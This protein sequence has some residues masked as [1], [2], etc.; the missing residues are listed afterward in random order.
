MG[1]KVRDSGTSAGDL[2]LKIAVTGASGFIGRHVVAELA[3]RS[4]SPILLLR[5]ASEVP[6]GLLPPQIVRIDLTAPPPDAFD[7]MGRPDALIHL[8][9][10]GLPN[11]RSLHHFEV[12]L[13]AQYRFLKGL[14]E[15]GLE[16]LLV[17][18]TCFEY[19]MQSGSLSEDLDAKPA[20][21]YGFAKDALRRQLEFLRESK[22]F[23]LTWARLF[24]VY[25]EGQ[26]TNSIY[27]QLK[28]AV[29]RHESMFNMSEGEQLRDYLPA[30][31]VAK[32]LVSLALAGSNAG[33]VN[34][35]SGQPVS[36]RKLVERWIADNG[37]SIGMNLGYYP[38]S[39]IEP[40]AFWGDRRKLDH[41][42]ERQ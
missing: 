29:E 9:W 1:W 38:Y 5:P 22:P 13:P 20:S 12:E 11:Y 18:G 35:C 27:S 2:R 7:V 41:C 36:I 4:I 26:A 37:W 14:L 8:A 17:T 3:R 16:S 39:D 31:D 42:Q 19:G 10:S 34:V 25:G 32:H 28:C 6:E 21:P 23:K 40:L 33:I 15:A 30:G 24:Y